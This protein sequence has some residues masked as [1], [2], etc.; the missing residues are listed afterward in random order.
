MGITKAI[1]ITKEF[2]PNKDEKGTEMTGATAII[3]TSS[4]LPSFEHLRDLFAEV[5][6]DFPDIQPEDV[7]LHHYSHEKL[8]K[9][10]GLEFK[11]KKDDIPDEYS[12]IDR[13]HFIL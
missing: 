6:K 3:R 12:K 8:R 13:H 2:C 1:Y 11:V 4:Q 7:H 9:T 5:A 10:F